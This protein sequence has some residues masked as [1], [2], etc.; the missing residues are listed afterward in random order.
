MIFFFVFKYFARKM[1]DTYFQYGQSYLR[2]WMKNPIIR[3]IE[4]WHN[5]N[6]ENQHHLPSNWF[7]EL[8]TIFKRMR[9]VSSPKWG[10]THMCVEC[11]MKL[12]H[13]QIS[14]RPSCVSFWSHEK[15]RLWSARN[16]FYEKCIC[17]LFNDNLQRTIVGNSFF[18]LLVAF[19]LNVNVFY[20]V[21]I[22]DFILNFWNSIK[23]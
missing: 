14:H 20:Y 7:S 21:L 16:K 13:N 17:F 19:H 6:H 18:S 15:F 1:T 11:L 22:F 12:Q 23:F 4:V 8:A 3:I 5:K 9:I 2:C 10:R